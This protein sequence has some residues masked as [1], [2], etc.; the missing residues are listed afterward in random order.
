MKNVTVKK[1][2]Y[3]SSVDG[4]G[5]LYADIAYI[6]DGRPKPVLAVMHGFSG[7]RSVVA[8]DIR[9]LAARGLF[10]IAPDMRGC[11]E[12]GGKFDSGGLDVYDAVDAILK[13]IRVFS[14]EVEPRNINMT[15]YSGGGGCSFGAFVRFPDLFQVVAP[16]FGIADYGLWHGLQPMVYDAAMNAA[17]GG[18][19]AEIPAVY[20]ARNYIP[21][22]SNNPTA[23]LHVF[24]DEEETICPPV[25]TEKFLDVYHTAGLNRA[26]THISGREDAIRWHHTYRSEH[27][28]IEKGDAIITE[29]I[30]APLSN[31]ALPRKGTLTVCGYLVTRHFQVFIEDGS[32]GVAKIAYDLT[33]NEPVIRILENPYDLA[34]RVST[35]TPLSVL[36]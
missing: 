13:S 20:A 2:E 5:P 11:G 14:G 4:S 35:T 16:F 19:P 10:C 31:T 6:A 17:L 28:D 21:G 1:I 34:I 25:M 18:T 33:G 36:P 7:N 27:P 24:W 15:G 3:A 9:D 29:E 12:S 32:R 26:V 22:A 23:R 8:Q 30:F